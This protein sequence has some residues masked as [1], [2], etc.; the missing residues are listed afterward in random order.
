MEDKDVLVVNL[1]GSPFGYSD[2]EL[3][4]IASQLDDGWW[5]L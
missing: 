1:P 4:E 3:E 5:D 2:G